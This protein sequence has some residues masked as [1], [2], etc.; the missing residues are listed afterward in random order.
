MAGEALLNDFDGGLPTPEAYEKNQWHSETRKLVSYEESDDDIPLSA[1]VYRKSTLGTSSSNCDNSVKGP[2][3]LPVKRPLDSSN[4]L[5]ILLKKSKVSSSDDD[6]DVPLSARVYRKSTLGTSSSNCDNSVKGPRILPVKRPLDS[7]NSLHI[8][9]KKSKVSSSDDD[10]DDDDLPLSQRIIKKPAVSADISFSMIKKLIEKKLA[11]IE[12]SIEE[13]QRKKH[14]EEQRLHSLERNIEECSKELVNKK[15]QVRC[16]RK[17]REVHNKLQIKIEECVKDLVVKEA[18]L[19]LME[20]LIREHEQKCKTTEIEL[21]QK[22]SSCERKEEELKALIRKIAERT[23]ELKTKEEELDAI[24]KLIAGQA[25]ELESERKKLLKVISIRR[26]DQR[27]QMK[28]F[29]SMKKQFERQVK[30][31]ESK[32]K[33]CEERMKELESKEKH[34]EERVKEL[35][36]KEKQLEGRVKVFELK[37]EE[38]EKELKSEKKRFESQVKELELKDK[39]CEALIEWDNQFS[40]T[41]EKSLQLLPSEQ[42]DELES[43]GNDIL[44]NLM[45]SSDPAK[46]ILDMIQNPIVPQCKKGDYAVIIDDSHIIL[47]EQLMRISP[48]IKPHVREEAMK[49]ALDLKANMSENT[50]KS[51][52]VLSFLLLLSIYGL[53]PSFDEDEVIKLFD[54]AAQHK[55]AVELFGTLGFADKISGILIIQNLIKKQHHIEAARFICA[56]KFADKNQPVDL[57]REYDKAR[58]QEIASLRT[59]LQCISD[60]NL[61]SKD[62]L[63]QIQDRIVKLNMQKADRVCSATT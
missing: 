51:M 17:I 63:N 50:E 28:D 47:L 30:E 60:N 16:I 5:H 14:V 56:Y 49:L 36:S 62:L 29:E 11:L 55:I 32:E 54:F 2:R 25:K 61:E 3:I 4:S 37:E 41:I 33:Q 20:D 26:T 13:C 22:F 7:S 39:Q 52:V 23:E 43:P 53:L 21:H 27:A 58:D 15:K 31:L 34:F 57:L 6:D 45:A 46:V 48:H 10:R 19:S 12:K 59:V 40:P 18:E 9:A 38:F 8:S 24:N 42:T 35:D 1:K 44:V